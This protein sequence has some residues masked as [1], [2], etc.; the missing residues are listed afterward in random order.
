VSIVPW[1]KFAAYRVGP[2]LLTPIASPVYTA[3]LAP[4]ST[5]ITAVAPPRAVIVPSSEAKMKLE[6]AA[7]VVAVAGVI[8]KFPTPYP[9]L[10]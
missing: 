4:L 10:T 1:E 5:K 2:A 9:V 3:P 7:G 8:S 6:P